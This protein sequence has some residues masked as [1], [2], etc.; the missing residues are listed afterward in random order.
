MTDA[1]DNIYE[2][3][4]ADVQTAGDGWDELPRFSTWWVLLLT[5]ATLA[6]FYVYW[7]YD[8]PRRF[9]RIYPDKP[10]S[11]LLIF[12]VPVLWVGSMVLELADLY[13]GFALRSDIWGTPVS[14][15]TN[16]S[17][18]VWAFSIRERINRLMFDTGQEM[19]TGPLGTFFLGVLSF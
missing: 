5:V 12:G 2:P 9:N 1:S 8:R 19:S 4:K 15:L 13:F 16:I 10:I 18:I 6:L 14:L 17:G 7:M 11:D 3:P